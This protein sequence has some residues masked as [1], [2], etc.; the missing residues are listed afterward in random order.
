[1]KEPNVREMAR[2][3][4]AANAK[5]PDD[6]QLTPRR[7]PSRETIEAYLRELLRERR[8]AMAVGAWE[9]PTPDDAAFARPLSED[10]L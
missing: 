5:L 8:E 4:E 3:V 1:M 6:E 2:Q 9:G 7:E 10:D